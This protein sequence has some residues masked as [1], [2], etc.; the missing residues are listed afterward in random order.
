MITE[1]EKIHEW[2]TRVSREASLLGIIRRQS[3]AECLTAIRNNYGT[4]AVM[5][6]V[7]QGKVRMQGVKP[8]EGI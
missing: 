8:P 4:L 2:L 6:K 1:C 5:I 3:P 7:A